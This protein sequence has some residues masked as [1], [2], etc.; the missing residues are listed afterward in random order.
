MEARTAP[1]QNA[2]ALTSWL[3]RLFG[4]VSR[5]RHSPGEGSEMCSTS[6]AVLCPLRWNVEPPSEPPVTTVPL[7]VRYSTRMLGLPLSTLI[8]PLLAPV[9][10]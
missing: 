10:P 4:A 9:R 6:T 5:T 1:C 3:L 7:G 2:V 8:A